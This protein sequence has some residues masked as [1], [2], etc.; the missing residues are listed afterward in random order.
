MT[1]AKTKNILTRLWGSYAVS[2]WNPQNQFIHATVDFDG[3]QPNYI[4]PEAFVGCIME[5]TRGKDLL[6]LGKRKTLQRVTFEQTMNVFFR[7]FRLFHFFQSVIKE[8]NLL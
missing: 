2:K 7:K 4:S 6:R 3:N 5:S 8:Q 1:S